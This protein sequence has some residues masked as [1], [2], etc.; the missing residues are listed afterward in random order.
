MG[1][2]PRTPIQHALR[3]MAR[4]VHD[5]RKAPDAVPDADFETLRQALGETSGAFFFFFCQ[6]YIQLALPCAHF[7]DNHNQQSPSP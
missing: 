3:E 5:R 7:T 2:T 4:N 1:D 6:T